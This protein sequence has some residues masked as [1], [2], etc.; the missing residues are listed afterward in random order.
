MDSFDFE[1]RHPI[2]VPSFGVCPNNGMHIVDSYTRRYATKI[3]IVA[4]LSFL[5]RQWVH[6]AALG[7]N[8]VGIRGNVGIHG[9]NSVIAFQSI[10]QIKDQLILSFNFLNEDFSQ[11]HV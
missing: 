1:L 4:F 7:R 3:H 5:L 11:L 10:E 9:I 6:V 8:A 2:L